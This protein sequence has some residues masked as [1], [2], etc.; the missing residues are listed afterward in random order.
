MSPHVFF[1]E[2]A[3]EVALLKAQ[4]GAGTPGDADLQQQIHALHKQVAELHHHNDALQSDCN[5][6]LQ[7][8]FLPLRVGGAFRG[9]FAEEG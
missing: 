2:G 8:P 4:L 7:V 6:M 5:Q 1:Q 3:E 9:W